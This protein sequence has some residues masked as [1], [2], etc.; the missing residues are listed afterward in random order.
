MLP[1]GPASADPPPRHLA[2]RGRGGP[3]G[4]G[5]R[6][7]SGCSWG[8][9]MVP[10]AAQRTWRQGCDPPWCPRDAKG[11][12]PDPGVPG[13]GVLVFGLQVPGLPHTPGPRARGKL[14]LILLV[15]VVARA[16]PASRGCCLDH[17]ALR[18]ER[19]LAVAGAT[20]APPCFL[21]R[22][23]WARQTPR[24]HVWRPGPGGRAQSL[25]EH[26]GHFHYV[27]CH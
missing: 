25:L 23:L 22:P 5:G 26:L 20:R 24:A 10:A 2:G 12:H 21:S 14:P 4:W 3:E 7:R 8:A 19:P 9:F 1:D 6:R 16:A 15:S 27:T 11:P 18:V 17:T 13:A